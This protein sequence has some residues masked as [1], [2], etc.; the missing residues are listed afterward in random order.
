MLIDAKVHG[1]V[2][3]LMPERQDR[4]RV[5]LEEPATIREVL[6]DHIGVNPLIF[7]AVV[8]DGKT[9]HLD[10]VLEDDSE[11]ILISPAAGG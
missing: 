5:S 11:L 7:A 3:S 6:R 1:H 10:Y 8:V 9:R 4:Y 2:V